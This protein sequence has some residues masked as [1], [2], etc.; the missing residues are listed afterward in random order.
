MEGVFKFA[1]GQA[2]KVV[3]QK[4]KGFSL[5]EVLVT[6]GV[7][8]I[9]T[10]IASVSYNSYIGMGTKSAVK[11]DIQKLQNSFELCLSMNSYDLTKCN[12]T[13]K[14]GFK[15]GDNIASIG[16]ATTG[17]KACL[18]IAGKSKRGR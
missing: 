16:V 8:A 15:A 11:Q 17:N 12:D 13:D 14:V 10:A 3:M 18:V 2:D 5:T 4:Q 6:V 9:I 7:M 1:R